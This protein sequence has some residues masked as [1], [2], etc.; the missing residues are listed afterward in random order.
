MCYIVVLIINQIE[1][2]KK[3]NTKNKNVVYDDVTNY[4]MTIINDVMYLIKDGKRMKLDSL[5]IKE[6]KGN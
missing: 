1:R 3:M 4:G 6:R 5:I 2:V